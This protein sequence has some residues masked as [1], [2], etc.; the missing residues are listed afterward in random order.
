MIRQV[1]SRCNFERPLGDSGEGTRQWR[2]GRG[3]HG[4]HGRNEDTLNP[5]GQLRRQVT[6][7]NTTSSGW[8]VMLLLLYVFFFFLFEK[9]QKQTT[10]TQLANYFGLLYSVPCQWLLSHRSS[11]AQ[12]AAV[13]GGVVAPGLLLSMWQATVL[14]GPVAAF[15]FWDFYFQRQF[16]VE[17]RI[18][19]WLLSH[20]ITA[21]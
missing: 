13:R 4:R 5:A 9:N 15:P 7:R 17:H 1:C 8:R 20:C 18:K 16:A 19:L 2:A 12:V 11:V 10:S 3:V 21:C 6:K 14:S